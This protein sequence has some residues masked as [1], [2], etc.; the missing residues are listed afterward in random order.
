MGPGHY[1]PALTE[2]MASTMSLTNILT[3]NGHDFSRHPGIRVDSPPEILTGR[4][5]G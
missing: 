4:L 3:L 5:P 2:A 1:R